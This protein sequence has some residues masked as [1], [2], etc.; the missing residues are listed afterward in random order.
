MLKTLKDLFDHLTEPAGTQTPDELAHHL[1]LAS[2]VLLVHVMQ[3]DEKGHAGEKNTLLKAL[4]SSFVL[5]DDEVGYLFALS[6]KTAAASHDYHHFTSQ[7]NEHCSQDQK[8]QLVENMWSV[9]YADGH[10]DENEHH[11]ISKIAGLLH[12][13]HGQYIAAKLH[14]KAASKNA[15][16]FAPVP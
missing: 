6:E 7:L 12:V 14:A 5:S 13:T 2:A 1:K 4:K 8:I 10:V 11:L 16:G 15:E 3:A 9:A